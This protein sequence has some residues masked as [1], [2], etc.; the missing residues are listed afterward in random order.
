LLKPVGIQAKLRVS[1]PGDPD[2]LEADRVADEIVSAQSETRSKA[3]PEAS[4]PDAAVQRECSCSGGETCH[5]CKK[6]ERSE[7]NNSHQSTSRPGI[8]GDTPE[9]LLRSLGAGEPLEGSVRERMES[10][11]GRDF[12]GVR[13]HDGAA[14]AA[15]A[16]AVE[17]RAFTYGNRVVFNSGQYSPRSPA[18]MRLIAHELAHVSQN[19]KSGIKGTDSHA[20]SAVVK[21]E[22]LVGKATKYLSEKKEAAGQYLDEKKWDVYRAMIAGLKASKNA[23][24][25][26]LR[27]MVPRFATSLQG[28]A[29][30]II[31][32]LDFILDMENALLLAIIGLAVGFVSGIVDLIVGLIKLALGLLRLVV[33]AFVAILGRSDEF[34]EDLDELAAAIKGIPSGLKKVVGEWL[35]RYKRA[36]PEEQVL[37]GG[38]LVGQ[39][40]AFIATFAL[41]GT[42]AGQAT[43]LTVRTGSA[44]AKVVAMRGGVAALTRVPE[45]V[46]IAIPAVVP[47]TAAEA[48]VV[49]SQAMMMSGPGQ[50]GGSGKGGGSSS[51]KGSSTTPKSPE[52]GEGGGEAKSAAKA[53]AEEARLQQKYGS[54]SAT[55]YP[56]SEWKNIENLEGRYPKLKDAQ[57][58]PFKRPATGDEA[59]FEE[60]M[61][62]G[63]GKYGLAAYNDKGELII[64]LDGISPNGF[65]EEIKIEQASEKVDEIMFQLRRQ[66]DFARGYGLKGVEYSIAPPSVAGEVER[67]VAEEGLKNVYRARG[68]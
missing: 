44:G 21:R 57:L 52:P 7:V 43:S 25:S 16:N 36:S 20:G 46:T 64:Q 68:T 29:S 49:S 62:T 38:E 39:I 26:Q 67:R 15:S 37:M 41:A 60:R 47:K 5:Q 40:E 59:I 2:E 32:A 22:S 42:K 56:A 63:Q 55:K 4:S 50:G 6:P 58:R 27:G 3:A 51:G 53:D 13:V 66:A 45:T 30:T 61:Q 18:G 14:A 19:Q 23:T 10:R 28:P 24:I 34:K 9:H 8:G 1:Q 11:F 35:E 12:S 31:D 54:R 48:A 17:A 33:D 65:V